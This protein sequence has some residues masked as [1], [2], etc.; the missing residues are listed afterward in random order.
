[1]FTSA[2]AVI[3]ASM[4]PRSSCLAAPS[5]GAS[6]AA[7]AEAAISNA[8]VTRAMSDSG[9]HTIVDPSRAVAHAIQLDAELIE[10][11][12]VQIR[13]RRLFGKTDMPSALEMSG[14]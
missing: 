4:R 8:V 14:A 1:M 7:A 11:R 12:Q 5:S 2:C 9:E 13:Q 6:A 10:Q 3:S